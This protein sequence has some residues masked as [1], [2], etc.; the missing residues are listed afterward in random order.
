MRPRKRNRHLPACVYHKHGAYYYVRRGKWIRLGTSLSDALARYSRL[1][2][3]E[4]GDMVALMNHTLEDARTRCSKNTMEQYEL[5]GRYLR[6]A[7]VEFAVDE[8]KPKH[9]HAIMEHWRDRPNMANR[10]RTLLMQAFT[11]AVQRGLR[12]SNP[13]RDI[14]RYSEKQRRRYITD[15]EW[16]AIYAQA[17]PALQCLMEIA[18]YTGQRISDVLAIRL[19]DLTD[20]GIYFEQRKTG[21]RLLVRYTPELR[22]AVYRARSLHRTTPMYLLGQRHGRQRSYTSVRDLLR[23][24]AH[25]A[26]VEDVGWHDIRAKSISDAKRQGLNAQALAGHTTEAQTVRY[27]RSKETPVVDGPG[28]FRQDSDAKR[29]E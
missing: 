10:I 3:S 18:Y 13:V 16:R 6:E 29:H 19:S 17:S 7:L 28:S 24:A 27:L 23:R 20:E 12:E 11:S 22:A 2:T 5:A 1:V 9:V 15:D 14:P 8:V 25:K 21:Q 4:G 26:G